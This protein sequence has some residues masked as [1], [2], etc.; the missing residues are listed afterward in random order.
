[1]AYTHWHI[2]AAALEAFFAA[3][4]VNFSLVMYVLRISSM[5]L[6]SMLSLSKVF[7]ESMNVASPII[8]CEVGQKS[9]IFL[10]GSSGSGTLTAFS[11]NMTHTASHTSFTP[12][13]GFASF[14]TS[15]MS[16]GLMVSRAFTADSNAG[17]AALKSAFTSA[18]TKPTSSAF[19]CAALASNPTSFCFFSTPGS[20][21][22][23]WSISTA[24]S[25]CAFFKIGCFAVSSSCISLTEVVAN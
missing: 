22:W 2:P 17:M 3:S 12:Y 19:F 8:F 5:H 10:V 24:V 11:P 16:L 9:M 13:G 4:G 25:S 15:L 21:A 1:M 23:T 14:F 20:F 18:A 6:M 7:N